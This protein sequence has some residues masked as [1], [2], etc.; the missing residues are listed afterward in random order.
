MD[1]LSSLVPIAI[2][3]SSFGA[4][5]STHIKNPLCVNSNLEMLICIPIFGIV[6]CSITA[7]SVSRTISRM[8][9]ISLL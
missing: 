6:D 2:L 9:A 7:S 4:L 3:F 1:N 5:N 8:R